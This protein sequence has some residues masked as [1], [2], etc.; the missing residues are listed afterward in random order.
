MAR[1]NLELLRKSLGLT[2]E[3]LGDKLGYTKGFVCNIENGRR[4]G[5]KAARKLGQ[6]FGNPWHEWLE[7]PE[8]AETGNPS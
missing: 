6:F 4:P 5:L 7:E 3:E 8:G 1:P 2:Q